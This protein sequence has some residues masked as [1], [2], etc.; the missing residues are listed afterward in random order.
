VIVAFDANMLLSYYQARTGLVSGGSSFGLTPA[1]TQYA[2]T[3][4]WAA[5]ST[6]ARANDLVRSALTGR[7]LI[8]EGAARLDLAGASADY[9]KLFALYQ[10][11]NSLYGLAERAGQKS[12]TS[13]ELSR[14][15]RVF[16][17]GL[18]EVGAYADSLKLNA[19]RLT[20]GEA[21][22]SARTRAGV[23]KTV[24]EYTTPVLHTGTASGEVA[25]FQG[26]AA[27]DLKVV[28]MGVTTNITVDLSEL[29]AEPRSMSNVVNLI[30]GKL[31]ASGLS[32]RF[33]VER[34]AA[35][36]RTVEVGGQSVKL[37][38]IGDAFAFKIK[39]D[40][41]EQLTFSAAS[42]P[43]V[44]LTTRAGDPDPDD[45]VKTDNGV[46][47]NSLFKLDPAGA[48][49][50]DTRI[51]TSELEGTISAVRASETGADGSLYLLADVEKT[52]DGQA[53]KG[54][55]DTVLL[56]YDSAGQLIY[57]RTLGAV[58][59][60]S[61]LALAVSDTG[62]IAVAGKV[63]GQLEGSVDGPI[64]SSDTSGKSDS[65]V[66]LFDAAGDELWTV[67]RGALEDDEA[68]AVAFS[69]DGTVYVAGRTSSA[70]P[71]AA[72][73]GGWDSYL[74]AFSTTDTGAPKTLFTHQFGTTGDD[75]AAGLVVDG[76]TVTV[77]SEESG[78]A[79]LRSFDVTLTETRT[80]KT[81]A[82]EQL[83]VAVETW[84]GGVLIDTQ[85]TVLDTPG[86]TDAQTVSSY[87]SAGALTAVA[88]RN[89]GDLQGGS[90]AGLKLDGGQLYLAGDTR[91]AALS[92]GGVSLAHVGGLD[93]FAAR[94][95]TDLG[96]TAEDAL[97]YYG[98]AGN[99]T[100]A[101]F[102]VAAGQVYLT[103]SA[104]ADLPGLIAVGQEDGYFAQ[105]DLAGGAVVASQRLSGKDGLATA[106]SIA[107]DTTGASDL[108]KF[109]LPAGLLD[110]TR[111]SSIVSA[112]AARAGDTFLIRT[113][114]GA[115]ASTITIAADDTLESLAAKIRRVTGFYAKVEVVSSG[116]SRILK[117]SPRSDS[118]TI[119]VLAGKGGTNVLGALGLP[120]GVAR[121]T[122]VVDG[123]SVSTAPGGNVYGLGLKMNISLA[124]ETSIKYALSVLGASL[125][126]IRTAYR[127]LEAA[128]KP[129][130][131]TNNQTLGPV[132]PYLQAQIAN[133]QAGLDRLTGGF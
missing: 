120:E 62:Q 88:T 132:S 83:T 33:T 95:S 2:P 68:S 82:A 103:G 106:T 13:G 94:I 26:A 123:K 118:N 52:I 19:L 121:R 101:G 4:P 6:F 127:D 43:A 117:I 41:A 39:G 65:F 69:A 20:R 56:K 49:L 79:V 100:A 59:E 80:T 71:G 85:S 104:G 51:R 64:N 9:K 84:T 31:E 45:D 66:T 87:I 29:G 55:A 76:N 37:P 34:T 5:K 21:F 24:Y 93:A 61:G 129:P 114:A 74:T 128:A 119:E 8:D 7:R 50:P 77:A 11:L 15:Q 125:S 28:R 91:N 98:G 81:W 102:D 57:A 109:G 126:K 111:S 42:R 99:N 63:T 86:A 22:D 12:I 3:A 44:Y 112:T 32:T 89:L 115:R 17:R 38:A 23:P 25:A 60:S 30:N 16:D 53:I 122:E 124:D 14:L 10:G 58:D 96:S 130:S 78:E 97:A 67:R 72:S 110:F 70:L 48:S 116:D 108:D 92:V 35:T 107:V 105:L 90:I 131:L 36:D 27:F 113:R 1:K 40:S 73:V 18:V 47:A 133:Y 54:E 46:F 75:A